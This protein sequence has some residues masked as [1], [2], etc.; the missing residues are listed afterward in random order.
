VLIGFLLIV[1][2]LGVLTLLGRRR[3]SKAQAAAR[4]QRPLKR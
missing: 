3:Q 1:I 4:A 2:T